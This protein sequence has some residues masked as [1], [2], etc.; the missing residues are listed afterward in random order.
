MD[1]ERGEVRGG[2]GMEGAGG[3]SMWA[4]GEYGAHT[5][6]KKTNSKRNN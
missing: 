4:H 6:N 5:Q 2:I 1:K 3:G